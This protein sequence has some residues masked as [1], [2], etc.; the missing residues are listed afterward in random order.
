MR[1][2][3]HKNNYKQETLGKPRRSSVAQVSN[4]PYRRLPVGRA[5]AGTPDRLLIT[6]TPALLL[7]R[8]PSKLAVHAR[9]KIQADLFRADRFTGTSHRTVAKPFRVHRLH[10]V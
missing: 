7:Q 1:G 2:L 10:H 6:S 3:T 8:R 9:D 5:Y 4:L